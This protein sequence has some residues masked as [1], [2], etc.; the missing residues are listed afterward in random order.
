MDYCVR[1]DYID[2]CSYIVLCQFLN[3]FWCTENAEALRWF[4]LFVFLPIRDE[5]LWVFMVFDV[6][7]F[8]ASL[9]RHWSNIFHFRETIAS[10]FLRN[11]YICLSA[12]SFFCFWMFRRSLFFLYFCI[13]ENE[14]V[15]LHV[16]L[17]PQPFDPLPLHRRL[18]LSP[19]SWKL[20][21]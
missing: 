15:S 12:D 4:F 8:W 10:F 13:F 1:F 7:P 6:T 20:W 2:K 3:F 17:S 16:S 11:A 19:Q 18:V 14:M 9:H 5:M 21:K